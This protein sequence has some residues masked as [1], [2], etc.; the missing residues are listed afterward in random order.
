VFSI[1]WLHFTLARVVPDMRSGGDTDS[2]PSTVASVSSSDLSLEEVPPMADAL[3][4]SFGHGPLE[5][6]AFFIKEDMVTIQVRELSITIAGEES[7]SP[8]TCQVQNMLFRIP[9]YVLTKDSSYFSEI[10][11]GYDCSKVF[12]LQDEDVSA[13]A[14]AHF[15]TVL[16]PR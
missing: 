13:L 1:Q 3:S 14:F 4:S 6:P 5:H 11:A 2:L 16:L 7:I 12:Q 9:L 8:L 10:L 15:L